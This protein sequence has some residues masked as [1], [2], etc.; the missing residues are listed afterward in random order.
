MDEK[1]EVMNQTWYKV[2]YHRYTV[3]EPKSVIVMFEYIWRLCHN[4]DIF[5]HFNGTLRMWF[6]DLS[7][8]FIFFYDLS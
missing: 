8:R 7:A 2:C 3:K 5:V 4:H 1:C 6:I